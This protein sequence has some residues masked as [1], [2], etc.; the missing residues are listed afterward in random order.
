MFEDVNTDGAAVGDLGH[1]SLSEPSSGKWSTHIHVV[2]PAVW[3]VCLLE[4]NNN[5]TCLVLNMTFGAENLD[6]KVNSSQ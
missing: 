3:S 6:R 5:M 2:Y 4:Y 1:M